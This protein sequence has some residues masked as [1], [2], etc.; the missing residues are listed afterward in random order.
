M[1]MVWSWGWQ[2]GC[3]TLRRAVG[4]SRSRGG[5]W[6]VLRAGAYGFLSA[7]G[8]RVRREAVRPPRGRPAAA[9]SPAFAAAAVTAA[10]RHTA[11][12]ARALS[13]ARQ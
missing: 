12:L 11:A 9:R 2:G 8:G 6:S 7:P 5:A 3:H 4:A 10:P 1:T 13:R